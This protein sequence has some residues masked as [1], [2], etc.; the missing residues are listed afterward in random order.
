MNVA[1]MGLVFSTRGQR[2]P[3][4]PPVTSA[5]GFVFEFAKSGELHALAGSRVPE[6]QSLRISSA[7]STDI[8]YR[9]PSYR[10]RVAPANERHGPPV[11]TR[12]SGWWHYSEEKQR[13]A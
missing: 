12:E 6:A 1:G 4:P 11:V 8:A 13:I 3:R 10:S 5:R 9:F 2:V 7:R